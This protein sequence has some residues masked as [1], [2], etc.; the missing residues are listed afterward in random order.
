MRAYDLHARAR[1]CKVAQSVWVYLLQAC[2]ATFECNCKTQGCVR[3]TE[4]AC[5]R[6]LCVCACVRVCVCVCACVCVCVCA[7]VCVVR[8]AYACARV[9]CVV[10]PVVLASLLYG[11]SSS[12]TGPGDY[13][14]V[15]YG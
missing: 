13:L 6:V 8:C 10:L 11:G 2:V 9:C 5:S 14:V 15:V 1:E 4:I 3:S 12:R 7:C